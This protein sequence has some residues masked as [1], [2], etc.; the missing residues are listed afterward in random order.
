LTTRLFVYGTL[1]PGHEAWT[2]LE[3]WVVGPPEPDSAP[4]SLYDTGRG[5]PAA[6]F[7]AATGS[8]V[9]GTVVRLDPERVL[10]ALAALDRYEGHEYQRI[11]LR[12]RAGVEAAAYA[13]IA[14]LAG[15]QVLTD[16]R[17]NRT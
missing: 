12:T 13:W 9:H 17:W 7:G 3:P 1:S 16:G 15:C 14:S 6:T 8:V 10:A 2:V 5:Y 11:T 4:G